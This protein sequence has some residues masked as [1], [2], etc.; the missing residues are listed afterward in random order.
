MSYIQRLLN[1]MVKAE[2]EIWL[3]IHP[4]CAEHG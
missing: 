3:R 4:P 2:E 1:D